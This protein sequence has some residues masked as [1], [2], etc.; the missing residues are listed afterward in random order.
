MFVCASCLSGVQVSVIVHLFA[1]N[2]VICSH[3]SISICSQIIV[4]SFNLLFLLSLICVFCSSVV[5]QCICN[6]IQV[7]EMVLEWVAYSTTKNGLK[8]TVDTL[9]LFEHEVTGT[10]CCPD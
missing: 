2:S 8:L 5:E 3:C 10:Y 1:V 9:E 4:T 6:R 7:D